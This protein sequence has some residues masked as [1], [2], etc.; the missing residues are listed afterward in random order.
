MNLFIDK[1]IQD[2]AY[3]VND[4]C[5][6][7]EKRSHLQ[8]LEAVLRQHKYPQNFINNYIS[9]IKGEIIESAGDTSATTFYHE[10][11]SGIAAVKNVS[12]S[13]FK[14]GEN[15]KKYFDDGT[16]APVNASL[17]TIDMMKM[18]QARFL[19]KNSIPKPALVKDAISSGKAIKSKIGKFRKAYWAGPTNDGSDF[20]AA[21]IILSNGSAKKGVG[22]SLKYG[23]GQLK[24]LSANQFFQAIIGKS[25]SNFVHHIHD[26]TSDAWDKMT[27]AYVELMDGEIK[28]S[29]DSE[30]IKA[31]SSIKS[32]ISTWN[33]YQKRKIDKE[34]A[35]M[36]ERATGVSAKKMTNIKYLGRK[37]VPKFKS[38]WQ[39]IKVKFFDIFFGEFIK[40]YEKI[41]P[42]NLR[43]LLKRQLSVTTNDL[44]YSASGG[45]NLKMIPGSKRFDELAKNLDLSHSHKPSGSGYNFT[46]HVKHTP[47]GRELGAI[48]VIIRWKQGQMAGYPDT[49]SSAKWN[50][51]NDEWAE[52]FN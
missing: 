47:S 15:V 5:P 16:I 38:A 48:T 52:I 31:F 12:A 17:S 25:D 43:N 44:W 8:I 30:A 40:T 42:N 35:A 50:I 33:G 32:D 1:I 9:Q 23:A 6:D 41:I 7:P 46:I 21:D 3:K 26:L 39:P 29:G 45:K 49:T 34:T 19:E 20:G 24:N 18:K 13:D 2:W 27:K 22:V 14:T 11:I 36:F 28:A 51:N 37:L 10:I 4:G